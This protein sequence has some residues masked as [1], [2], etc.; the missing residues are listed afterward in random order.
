[1]RKVMLVIR[2]V[3]GGLLGGAVIFGWGYL[4][5]MVL[6]VGMMGVRPISNEESVMG[7]MRKMI[8]EPGLYSFPYVDLSKADAQAIEDWELKLKRGPAGILVIQPQR[9]EAISRRQLVT[10]AA[11]DFVAALLAAILL[12]TVR[13][14]YGGRVLFVTLLGAFA[15]VTTSVPAWNWDG[16]P[17]DF[18]SAQAMQ[19][20]VG[21]LLAGIV[22]AAIVWGRKEP[23]PA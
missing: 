18:T 17:L 6:P 16:F 2:V 14:G 19:Q 9:A 13:L 22:L 1:M 12:S 8:S 5:H 15:F 23:V 20:V 11:T 10:E 4:T 21:W 3:L 7:E